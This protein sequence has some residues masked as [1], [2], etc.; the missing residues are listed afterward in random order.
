MTLTH[1]SVVDARNIQ[2]RE[3]K[4]NSRKSWQGCTALPRRLQLTRAFDCLHEK[5]TNSLIFPTRGL[6]E[7]EVVELLATNKSTEARS[8]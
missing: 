8:H 6:K 2:I 4:F 7:V 5:F 1:C 3:H